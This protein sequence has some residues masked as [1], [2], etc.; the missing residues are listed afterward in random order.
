[1]GIVLRS[2]TKVQYHESK[3]LPILDQD[4]ASLQAG[5]S[6]ASLD[7]L[8]SMESRSAEGSATALKERVGTVLVIDDSDIARAS[9]VN[10]LADAGLKVVG[11]ASPIGA[12]RAILTHNV[13]VVVVD[14]LMPGMRGDRLAALF[15]GNPRFKNLGVVLVSGENGLELDRLMRETGADAAVSKLELPSLVPA[16]IRASRKR[17]ANGA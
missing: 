3:H 16:V 9:M 11:L 17:T 12:T 10:V 6:R 13:S 14:I 2:A 1:M 5:T 8:G 15:R 7:G 4:S